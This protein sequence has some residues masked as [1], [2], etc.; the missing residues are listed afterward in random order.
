[1]N[2]CE[3]AKC[4]DYYKNECKAFGGAIRCKTQIEAEP[5]ANARI[6]ARDKWWVTQ[7]ESKFFAAIR[8]RLFPDN[9][10]SC[11]VIERCIALDWQQFKTTLEVK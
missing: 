4:G 8:C 2:Y 6:A 9:C 1:M 10:D 7:M 3:W 11:S 5:Y